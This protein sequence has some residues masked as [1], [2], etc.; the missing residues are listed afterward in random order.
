MIVEVYCPGLPLVG[1]PRTVRLI[2]GGDKPRTRD[3]V[4][5]AAAAVREVAGKEWPW[6]VS[7]IRNWYFCAGQAG[8]GLVAV[9][10]VPNIKRWCLIRQ[11]GQMGVVWLED[12]ARRVFGN[13]V[14][15]EPT[16]VAGPAGVN[17]GTN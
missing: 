15:Y 10:W 17:T 9:V 4:E 14:G 13:A 12:H 7:V 2:A 6:V 8:A 5:G 3:I 16:P 11:N 1:I